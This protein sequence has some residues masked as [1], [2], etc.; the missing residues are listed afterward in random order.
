VSGNR[1]PLGGLPLA[2]PD[3]APLRVNAVFDPAGPCLE[4]QVAYTGQVPCTGLLRCALCLCTWN[5]ATGA[6]LDYWPP[7]AEHARG[8]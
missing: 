4:H 2:Q 5:P 6:F 3:P 7:A 1:T 8:R